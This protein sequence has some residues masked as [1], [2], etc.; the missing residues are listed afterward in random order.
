MDFGPRDM[1]YNRKRATCVCFYVSVEAQ[2]Y[3]AS[4][5]SH[6]NVKTHI[7]AVIGT[8]TSTQT[9]THTGTHTRT[10]KHTYKH[11][12]TQPYAKMGGKDW[13]FPSLNEWE[14]YSEYMYIERIPL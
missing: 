8:H 3:A 14:S 5:A 7:H 11:I 6:R 4:V 12:Y 9:C 1:Q 13:S 2:I 10:L